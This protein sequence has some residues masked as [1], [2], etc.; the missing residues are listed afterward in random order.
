MRTALAFAGTAR[1]KARSPSSVPGPAVVA[2]DA[3]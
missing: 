3:S 2:A 1:V